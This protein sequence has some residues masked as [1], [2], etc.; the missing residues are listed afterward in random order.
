MSGKIVVDARICHL[1]AGKNNAQSKQT[2]FVQNIVLKEFFAEKGENLHRFC[3]SVVK[4]CLI[5]SNIKH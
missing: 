3:S 4:W 5:D 2:T 1:L